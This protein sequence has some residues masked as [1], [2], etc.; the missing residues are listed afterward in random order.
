M[1]RSF[2]ELWC[3]M[4]CGEYWRSVM[5]LFV[6]CRFLEW[7]R[8]WEKSHSRYIV[9]FDGFPVSREKWTLCSSVD[10]SQLLAVWGFPVGVR[11]WLLW[12]LHFR[13]REPSPWHAT[14]LQATLS[15]GASSKTTVG[16]IVLH[17]LVPSCFLVGCAL[18]VC[19]TIG[20]WRISSANC[21]PV[22]LEVLVLKVPEIT[23]QNGV[24]PVVAPGPWTVWRVFFCRSPLHQLD[25]NSMRLI[26]EGTKHK[27]FL[28]E[29]VTVLL[30][31]YG[32]FSARLLSLAVLSYGASGLKNFRYCSRWCQI[33]DVGLH[34]S[35]EPGGWA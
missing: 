3:P 7:G 19:W 26:Y 27:I 1:Y 23:F 11:L 20:I 28:V 10:G 13:S 34:F 6:L 14:G 12:S 29:E 2:T 31:F 35:L 32:R 18:I 25:S 33:L 15:S 22:S 5:S 8:S 21:F 16:G 4:R 9:H 30:K 24:L 17:G